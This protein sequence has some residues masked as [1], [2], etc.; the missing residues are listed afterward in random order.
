MTVE[1]AIL[2]AGPHGREISRIPGPEWVLYDDN[3][4]FNLEPT[5]WGARAY[6]WV[7]GAAWPKVRREIHELIVSDGDTKPPWGRAAIW[8]PGAEVSEEADY[9]VHV[10]IGHNAVVS[11]GC[12]LGDFVTVCPGAILSGD[13]QVGEG[14]LIGAGATVIH[15]GIT[16]GED[17]VVG[18]GAV[19]LEDVP[20]RAV[21]A[22]N[23]S[24]VIKVKD[25]V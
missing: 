25:R 10:H 2:G 18:A 9:G 12:Y 21:V 1:I 16:I 17:A 19:V 6:N 24:K 3:P 22:G 7:I 4:K 8:F 20:P 15:G 23:P 13:V 11:H 5:D 14:A